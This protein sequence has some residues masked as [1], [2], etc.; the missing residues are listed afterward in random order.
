MTAINILPVYGTYDRS[1]AYYFKDNMTDIKWYFSYH[2]CV[3][4]SHMLVGLVC[5]KNIWGPTT[6]RHLNLIQPD[7]TLRVDELSFTGKLLEVYDE[8]RKVDSQLP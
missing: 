6:G 1:N 4:F 7:K 3:A 8:V 5:R 2:T